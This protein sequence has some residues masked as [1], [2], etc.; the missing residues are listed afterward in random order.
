MG[1]RYDSVSSV[2]VV[3]SGMASAIARKEAKSSCPL[4][5]I[6]SSVE[7]KPLQL[8]SIRQLKSGRTSSAYAYLAPDTCFAQSTEEPEQS[9]GIEWDIVKTNKEAGTVICNRKEY[10]EFIL[11][12][13]ME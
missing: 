6:W 5:T 4:G 10:P 13:E 7:M 9:S 8:G 3:Y 2:S 12:E 11:T 1:L